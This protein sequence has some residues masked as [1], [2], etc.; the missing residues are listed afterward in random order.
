MR[1]GRMGEERK[2]ERKSDKGRRQAGGR[3][4]S[5]LP[6]SDMCRRGSVCAQWCGLTALFLHLFPST[7]NNGQQKLSLRPPLYDRPLSLHSLRAS[8]R[9]EQAPS[10]LKRTGL[11]PLWIIVPLHSKGLVLGRKRDFIAPYPSCVAHE[12]R[13]HV[14][15]W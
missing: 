11:S 3:A 4:W 12:Q 5:F 14:A 8:T 1:D 13:V 15:R 2:H 7:Q 9:H 10:S 6:P